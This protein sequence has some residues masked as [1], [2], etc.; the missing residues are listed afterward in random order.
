[1]CDFP[2][3]RSCWR[4]KVKPIM[5]SR[6]AF[7]TPLT[8]ALTSAPVRP[9]LEICF[10]SRRADRASQPGWF[11]FAQSFRARRALLVSCLL[12]LGSPTGQ[13]HPRLCHRHSCLLLVRSLR[14]FI[15]RHSSNSFTNTDPHSLILWTRPMIQTCIAIQKREQSIYGSWLEEKT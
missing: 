1:M 11:I 13:R 8:W 9:S 2:D 14:S 6:L 5:E 12:R 3:G 10:I 4:H 7:E 15:D